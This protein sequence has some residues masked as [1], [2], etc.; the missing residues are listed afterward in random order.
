[1]HASSRNM[2]FLC[3]PPPQPLN[4]RA[5]M[6]CIKMLLNIAH[7]LGGVLGSS[8]GRVLATVA[9]LDEVLHLPQVVAYRTPFPTACLLLSSEQHYHA[10][11]RRILS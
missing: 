4:P 6:Q 2:A 5:C 1:M 9:A 3:L 8:W 11:R 10:M 7:C